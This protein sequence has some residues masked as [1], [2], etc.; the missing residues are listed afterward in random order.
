MPPRLEFNRLG[1]VMRHQPYYAARP[2]GSGRARIR[3]WSY[4]LL[5]LAVCGLAGYSFFFFADDAA[6]PALSAEARA[7]EHSPAGHAVAAHLGEQTVSASINVPADMNLDSAKSRSAEPAAGIAAQP[8]AAVAAAIASQPDK[9]APL[10]QAELE[11][12]DRAQSAL[13]PVQPDR[14]ARVAGADTQARRP[15][16]SAVAESLNP[17]V[18]KMSGLRPAPGMSSRAGSESAAQPPASSCNEALRAMQL[19]ELR[20]Q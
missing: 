20:T 3:Q 19:C 14:A 16:G 17:S 18:L 2:T 8:D 10:P 1:H 5:A 9:L 15:A 12:G 6:Q 7:Y 11:S 13:M 4:G